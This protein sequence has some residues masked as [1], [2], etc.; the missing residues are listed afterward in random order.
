MTQALFA[1]PPVS[2][3]AACLPQAGL[4]FSSHVLAVVPALIIGVAAGLFA[5]AF[6]YVNIKVRACSSD[7]L[8]EGRWVLQGAD[9]GR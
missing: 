3:P 5:I 9:T 4:S 8:T 2:T 1:D 7:G 6:T